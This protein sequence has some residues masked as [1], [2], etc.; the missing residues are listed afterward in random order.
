MENSFV[1][2][3]TMGM[4]AETLGGF[5]K[6]HRR[7]GGWTQVELADAIDMNN[8]SVSDWEVN[9]TIPSRDALGKLARVF[10]ISLDEF[11]RFLDIDA[12][13]NVPVLPP[14][15]EEKR[16]RAIR[17]IDELLADPRKLDQWVDYG[18]WLRSRGESQ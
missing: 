6:K 8:R 4:D 11:R 1:L 15:Q 16:D 13:D 12:L 3:D 9:R 17:L 2:C 7:K 18:E 14:E 10:Q 5:I